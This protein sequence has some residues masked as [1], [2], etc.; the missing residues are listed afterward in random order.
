MQK[1]EKIIKIMRNKNKNG[2]AFMG[3]RMIR[4]SFYFRATENN[5]KYHQRV[6]TVKGGHKLTYKRLK[7]RGTEEKQD[8]L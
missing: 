3:S 6:K 8:K 2:N 4:G 5:Q 7:Y 1:L